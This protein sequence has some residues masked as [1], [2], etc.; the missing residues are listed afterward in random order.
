MRWWWEKGELKNKDLH[1]TLRLKFDVEPKSHENEFLGFAKGKLYGMAKNTNKTIMLADGTRIFIKANEENPKIFI[2]KPAVGIGKRF[3]KKSEY[4][5]IPVGPLPVFEV[6][7]PPWDIYTLD[8]LHGYLINEDNLETFTGLYFS[9]EYEDDKTIYYD[10]NGTPYWKIMVPGLVGD[11]PISMEVPSMEP[12]ILKNGY[13]YKELDQYILTGRIE[14]DDYYY[15]AD[16][17]QSIYIGIKVVYDL[18]TYSGTWYLNCSGTLYYI[19]AGHLDSS[20][21]S[22]IIEGQMLIYKF[23]LN[24]KNP[25]PVYIYTWHWGYPDGPLPPAPAQPY[26]T[27]GMVYKG[28]NHFINVPYDQSLN[29]SGDS[30][31]MG[32]IS[33]FP[34]CDKGYGYLRMRAVQKTTDEYKVKT[35]ELP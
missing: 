23:P 4:K 35:K 28:E 26:T 14:G 5:L 16:E 19:W 18:E 15:Y 21:P 1:E 12:D 29:G 34:D 2:T 27:Y 33:A 32:A 24:S 8:G 7:G 17:D 6:W 31:L 10:K 9:R 3:W 20:L 30:S 11:N 13:E 25:E 22:E